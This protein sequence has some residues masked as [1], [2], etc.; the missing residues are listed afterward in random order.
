MQLHRLTP[1]GEALTPLEAAAAV[2]A[3]ERAPEDR[4]YVLA[5]MVASADGRATVAGRSGGLGNE[6][7][8]Q[9][10]HALREQADAILVGTG[11]L[12]VER[13]GR[14]VRDPERRARREAAGR[15]PDPLAVVVT[16]SLALPA[17][18]PL[19]AD[20]DS[21][22]VVYTS[23]ETEAPEAAADVRL[24]RLPPGA[25]TM[26]TV[27][28]RLRADHGVRCLL[29]EGGPT[30]LGALVAEDVLDELFLSVAPRLVGA[31]GP[32][33]LEGPGRQEPTELELAWT[34][35]S[36]GAL[37]LRYVTRR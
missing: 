22:I 27:L 5:N 2:R 9:L 11:T 35:E 30:I 26:T 1:D 18:I 17:D 10:F 28:E 21:T 7:D 14:L 37:F 3:S 31:A 36:E 13:Y 4:P 29:C 24:T 12:R 34:L 33:T 20:P 15:A 8:R 32:A 25:L 16:R 6:A 19:F 23:S